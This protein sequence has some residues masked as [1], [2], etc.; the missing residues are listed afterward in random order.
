MKQKHETNKRTISYGVKTISLFFITT[1]LVL[2][3]TVPVFAQSDPFK[4]QGLIPCGNEVNEAG[5][6]VNPCGFDD[7]IAL[8]NNVVKFLIWVSIPIAVIAFT[9]AGFLMLTSG[10]NPGQIDRAKGIFKNVAI[11]L[12]FVIS[13]WL[14]VYLIVS[15]L[16]ETTIYEMFF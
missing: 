16:A 3:S 2:G 10:G 11:G 8:V 7:F 12:I 6:L 14:I 9:Y 4:D 1:F 15:S 13:A 5:Q